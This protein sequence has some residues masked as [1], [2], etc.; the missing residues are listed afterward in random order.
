MSVKVNCMAKRCYLVAIGPCTTGNPRYRYL[1]P[2]HHPILCHAFKFYWPIRMPW[3]LARKT[4][5]EKSVLYRPPHSLSTILFSHS[6]LIDVYYSILIPS[7]KICQ[8]CLVVKPWRCY[9][10]IRGCIEANRLSN[11][12]LYLTSMCIF[13]ESLNNEHLFIKVIHIIQI[14]LQFLF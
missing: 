12:C 1:H 14:V 5:R 7:S 2:A 10:T 3:I 6:F 13:A 9:A 8:V 4:V 11:F